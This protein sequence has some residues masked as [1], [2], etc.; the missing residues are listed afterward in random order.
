[1][2]NQLFLITRGL[3]ALSCACNNPDP[4]LPHQEQALV[5]RQALAWEQECTQQAW[6]PVFFL[7]GCTEWGVQS[8]GLGF[9]VEMNHVPDVLCWGSL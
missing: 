6:P 1:M 4:S 9:R 3:A 7:V 5:Q 8:R 2:Y